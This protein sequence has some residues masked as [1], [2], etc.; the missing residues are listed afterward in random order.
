MTFNSITFLLFFLLVVCLYYLLPHKFRWILLL[1]ANTVFYAVFVP[2]YTLIF[3]STILLTYA[4]GILIDQE[5]PKRKKQLLIFGIIANL[6][7]LLFFKYTNFANANIA[8]LVKLLD[9]NYSYTTLMWLLPLGISFHTFQ[10]ISYL[11]DVFKRKVPVERHLGIFS[12]YISFFPQL[13]AGPIERPGHMLPQFHEKHAFSGS[14]TT[15]GLKRMALGFF[16]KMV[17]A[18]RL[19]LLVAAVYAVPT[20]A[21][22]MMLVLATLAFTFQI[23]CDF[24]GY[25]DIA[26]GAARVLGFRLVEN[27]DNPYG[28][29]SIK[30]FWKKWHM[31]LSYWFRDYIYIPLGGSRVSTLRHYGNLLAA[32]L[33]SG[34][35]HGANWTFVVWGLLHGAYIIVSHTIENIVGTTGKSFQALVNSQWVRAAQTLFVFFLVAFAWIFFRA[36]NLSDAWYIT[37]HIAKDSRTYLYI[38]TND[39]IFALLPAILRQLEAVGFHVT[40]VVITLVSLAAMFGMEYVNRAKNV[41]YSSPLYNWS[42]YGLVTLAIFNLSII[43]IVPF[44]YFQF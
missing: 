16:K 29:R 7:P 17:I 10:S 33:I 32:F 9:W 21:S 22:G 34:L 44:I 24:S 6:I 18:D 38:L 37:T 15:E 28:S 27:F 13:V 11:V 41:F 4:V 42:M 31:S 23:Y 14:G 30:D 43:Q 25:S 1:V 36:N 2:W 12:L 40:D 8:E 19:S 35:W 20:Q 3:A 5:K 26:I 39:G